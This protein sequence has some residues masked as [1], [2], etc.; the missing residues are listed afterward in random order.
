MDERC[1]VG[2]TSLIQAT[3]LSLQLR[4]AVPSFRLSLFCLLLTTTVALGSRFLH[5][6]LATEAGF[7]LVSR[8][9]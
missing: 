3:E 7:P 4:S 1:A 2:V 6:A 5:L 8:R 9:A